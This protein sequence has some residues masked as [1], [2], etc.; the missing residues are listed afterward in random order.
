MITVHERYTHA[1][2]LCVLCIAALL[3]AELGVD[4]TMITSHLIV[5]SSIESS[6]RKESL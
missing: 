6:T 4:K 1:I 5:F 2:L 3:Q